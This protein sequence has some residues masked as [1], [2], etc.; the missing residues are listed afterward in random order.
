MP[1]LPVI[2]TLGVALTISLSAA[3]ASQAQN[4]AITNAAP[5]LVVFNTA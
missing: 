5:G 2:R 1:L 3:E 4:V